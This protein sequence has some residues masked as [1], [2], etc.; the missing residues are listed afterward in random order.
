[1]HE[2][3][4]VWQY[5]LGY[6]VKL[7]GALRIGLSYEY[8]LAEGKTLADFNMEAQGDLLADYWALRFETP[9]VVLAQGRYAQSL[10]LFEKVLATFL[11]DPASKASLPGGN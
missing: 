3:V 10:P 5:Q 8:E 4:H 6:P 2:M 9:P 7:R 11:V 1:M